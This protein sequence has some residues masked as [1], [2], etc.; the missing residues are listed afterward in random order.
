MPDGDAA[1]SDETSTLPTGHPLADVQPPAGD[2]EPTNETFT[3]DTPDTE[4][5]IA[6]LRDELNKWKNLSKKNE[7][8]DKKNKA[9]ADE[10]R[11]QQEAAMSDTEKAIAQARR[12]GRLEA[13]VESG[14][15]V[16]EA[17]FRAI[18]KDRL[19]ETSVNKLLES[20]DRR[21][22]MDEEGNVDTDA[23]AAFVD[24]IAPPPPKQE[25]ESPKDP[26]WP[27]LGQGRVGTPPLNDSGLERALRTVVGG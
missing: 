20:I 16:I 2:T 21:T 11:R 27:D 13:L 4:K 23:I 18:A 3:D 14:S 8:L 22:F 6:E 5:V 1:A 7:A 15:R 17:T 26:R 9:A 19:A 12:E 24:S 10:H 25:D